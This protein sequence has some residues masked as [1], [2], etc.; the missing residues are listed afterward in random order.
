MLTTAAT[1]LCLCAMVPSIAGR[2]GV[3]QQEYF[4]LAAPFVAVGSLG[5]MGTG[6]LIADQWVVTAAHVAD[7]LRLR[8]KL[9]ITFTLDDGRVFTVDRVVIHPDWT[10]L[11]EQMAKQGKGGVFTA[12][13]CALLHLTEAVTGVEP[14]RLGAFD[15]ENPEVVLVGIGAF[16]DVPD[17]GVS[18]REAMGMERGVKHAGT[19]RVDG[20]DDDRHELIV[21]FTAPGEKDDTDHEASAFAGDSGGPVLAKTDRGW[22]I[23][24]VIASVDS[25]GDTLGH[26]GDETHATS[27][28]AVRA[29][30]DG[31]L[32]E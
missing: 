10:P 3:P 17:V 7:F 12:G 8:G 21:S 30:I 18:L 28:G 1:C 14:V 23:I 9:P 16:T 13:D 15:A 20:V 27:I 32:A 2:P 26:Y 4:E 25:Q 22:E 19:N 6:T 5:G 24:G 29:W 31:Q 11:E